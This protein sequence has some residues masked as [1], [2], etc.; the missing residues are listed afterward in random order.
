[1][2]FNS[3]VTV[4]KC[5]VCSCYKNNIL[6]IFQFSAILIAWKFSYFHWLGLRDENTVSK[7][8]FDT[9]KSFPEKNKNKNRNK[10]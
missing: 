8:M 5:L 3:G 10:Q 7:L 1:M 4:C 9:G 6:N 2:K